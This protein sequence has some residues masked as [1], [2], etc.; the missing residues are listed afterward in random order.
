M[1]QHKTA[2]REEWLAARNQLLAAEKELTRRGDQ[3]A[4]YCADD[5]R[6]E[7]G[8]GVDGPVRADHLG[9]R[10]ERCVLAEA[11][12]VVRCTFVPTNRH[13]AV[14]TVPS[15]AREIRRPRTDLLVRVSC[16]RRR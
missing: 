4:A 16:A 14:G 15:R 8:H 13:N 1:V 3:L 6:G 2:T 5:L 12:R 9:G 7:G 11:E 10:A